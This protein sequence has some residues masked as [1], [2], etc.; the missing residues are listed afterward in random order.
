MRDI[1]FLYA[2][3]VLNSMP[4]PL[5]ALR[6]WKDCLSPV[7]GVACVVIEDQ[8]RLLRTGLPF[9]LTAPVRDEPAL[10]KVMHDAGFVDMCAVNF[11][12]FDLCGK[13]DHYAGFFGFTS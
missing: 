13:Q 1:D 3:F 7:R 10:R 11:D 9:D 4:D 2:P 6:A 12:R 8:I 5:A